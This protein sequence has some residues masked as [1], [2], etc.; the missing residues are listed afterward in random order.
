MA[1]SSTA[2]DLTFKEKLKMESPMEQAD[3]QI[4]KTLTIMK[5]NGEKECLMEKANN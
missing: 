4:F 5:A 1:Y 2:M 3:L